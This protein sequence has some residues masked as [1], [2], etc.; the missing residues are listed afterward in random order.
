V[1]SGGQ[2]C[3]SQHGPCVLPYR[4]WWHVK[5]QL[6]SR[7]VC[8]SAYDTI[9]LRPSPPSQPL[10]SPC[11]HS[12]QAGARSGPR[13]RRS[14]L[15]TRKENMWKQMG[16]PQPPEQEQEAQ[17]ME[18]WKAELASLSG[19]RPLDLLIKPGTSAVVIT[20]PNTGGKT[21]AMKALGLSVCMARAGLMVPA[22]E[23]A[24]L[25]CFSAVLADIGDEQSLTA[26]LST[27]SGHLRRIQAARG[28]A[29]GKA[30]L[31]LDELGTG[32]WP[33]RAAADGGLA[34]AASHRPEL[35]LMCCLSCAHRLCQRRL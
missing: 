6:C 23:P 31:L 9:Q 26:S 34:C 22:D 10:I 4:R 2:L 5:D 15:S 35:S 3:G 25:P 16:L 19:P 8:I 30:L 28:E 12:P 32:G 33:Q 1:G 14:N 18:T 24:K 13:A 20:G 29:D 17:L 21:A 11:P 27:F 7:L